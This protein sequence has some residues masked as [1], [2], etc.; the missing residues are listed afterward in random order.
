MGATRRIRLKDPCSTAMR[1][2]ANITEVTVLKIVVKVNKHEK[3]ENPTKIYC[4]N[5]RLYLAENMHRRLWPAKASLS[6]LPSTVDHRTSSWAMWKIR[7]WSSMSLRYVSLL[8]RNAVASCVT[9]VHSVWTTCT[10]MQMMP[11]CLRRRS[12]CCSS[13]SS[14]SSCRCC[15]NNSELFCEQASYW[16]MLS[17]LIKTVL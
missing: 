13:C 2:V 3:H 1:T 9:E 11:R 6:R 10:Q 15:D 7:R 12:C 5:L 14:S 17:L 8:P 16:L 4:A